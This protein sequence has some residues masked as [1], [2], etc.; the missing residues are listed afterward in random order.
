MRLT[1]E[2]LAAHSF[3]PY[4]RL[5]RRFDHNLP[6]HANQPE[7]GEVLKVLL[8]VFMRELRTGNRGSWDLWKSKWFRTY[9]A[10][11]DSSKDADTSLFDHGMIMLRS[12]HDWREKIDARIGLANFDYEIP[13]DDGRNVLI[14]NIPLVLMNR[15]GGVELVF[16]DLSRNELVARRD[17]RM[18]AASHV[19]RRT[20][21][22]MRLDLIRCIGMDMSKVI[23]K[24]NLLHPNKEFDQLCDD[25]TR[26][27]V[28]AIS[29]GVVWPN[30]QS[31][32][33]CD[34]RESCRA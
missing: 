5:H 26:G 27:L 7:V 3:C 18:M 34:V 33:K 31:C 4:R 32:N 25:T 13:M 9:W 22:D 30:W 29:G 23:F 15:R 16:F 19:V 2:D 6:P 17:V 1:V 11:R 12:L 21:P 24:Q 20:L 28:A 10:D 8:F 14:G